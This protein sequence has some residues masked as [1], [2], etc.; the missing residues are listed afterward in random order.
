MLVEKQKFCYES[1]IPA[2]KSPGISDTLNDAKKLLEEDDVFSELSD[3]NEVE[4]QSSP[5]SRTPYYIANFKQ[6]LDTVLNQS[7]NQIL[8]NDK[9]MKSVEAFK[10]SSDA[11]QKLY[12]RLFQRKY[13]WLRINKIN[14]PDITQDPQ[15]ILEELVKIGLVDSGTSDIDLETAL[16]LL[17]LPEAKNLAKHFNFNSGKKYPL[18]PKRTFTR[19]LM[20]FSLPTLS[21]DEDEAAGGQQQQLMTL[22]QVNKGEL[23]FPDYKI[24]KKT[25]IFYDRDELIRYEEARQ[26]EC[27]IFNAMESKKFELAKELCTVAKEIFE[28]QCTSTFLLKEFHLYHLS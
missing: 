19:V 13:K 9:D 14:Y 25:V 15:N 16:E 2:V 17:S 18:L 12:V 28:D 24:T 20:L 1:S 5:K 6:I 4:K 8:F 23:V 22:L 21:D 11:A 10:A 27:D 26:L 3:N 7:D